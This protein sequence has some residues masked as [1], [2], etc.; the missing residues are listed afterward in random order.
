M[1]LI[2]RKINTEESL[3]KEESSIF[4]FN[5]NILIGYLE[6]DEIIG[7]DVLILFKFKVIFPK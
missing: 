4:S 1:S 6:N 7:D 5:N 3:I 2:S